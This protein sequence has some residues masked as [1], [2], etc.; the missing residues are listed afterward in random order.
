MDQKARRFCLNKQDNGS[1]RPK[2]RPKMIP[3][4]ATP[5]AQGRIDPP[6]KLH[7]FSQT[8]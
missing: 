4:Q 2:Q 6:K 1:F 7:T 5:F 8:D 3:L